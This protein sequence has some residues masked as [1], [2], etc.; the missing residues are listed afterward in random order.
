VAQIV[1]V[2]LWVLGVEWFAR[3]NGIERLSRIGIQR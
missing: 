3:R 1:T 2:A